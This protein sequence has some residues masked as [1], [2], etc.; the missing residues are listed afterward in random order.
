MDYL[1]KFLQKNC[2]KEKLTSEANLNSSFDIN[3]II[4]GDNITLINFAKL[5]LCIS[6]LCSIKDKHLTKV[7]FL[8]AET[9]NE[10]FSSVELFFSVDNNNEKQNNNFFDIN[11]FD[12]LNLSE[13]LMNDLKDLKMTEEEKKPEKKE[14]TTVLTLG[15]STFDVNNKISYEDNPFEKT[16]MESKYFG[17]ISETNNTNDNN[18][19]D[20]S[21]QLDINAIKQQLINNTK[22]LQPI[23]VEKKIYVNTAQ[24]TTE[25][26][27]NPVENKEKKNNFSN[28]DKYIQNPYTKSDKQTVIVEKKTYCDFVKIG[29]EGK[30]DITTNNNTKNTTTNTNKLTTLNSILN[31]NNDHLKPN[32]VNNIIITDKN[33]SP[34]NEISLFLSGGDF[35][36]KKIDILEETLMKNSEMYN[37]VIDKYEKE[38]KT[39]KEEI[40]NMKI[41]HKDELDNLSKEKKDYENKINNLSNLK[42]DNLTELDKIKNELNNEKIKYNELLIIKN[43]IEKEK[44]DNSNLNNIQINQKDKEILE[45]KKNLDELSKQLN[46]KDIENLQLKRTI[47]ELKEQKEKEL[48]DFQKQIKDVTYLKDQEISMLNDKIKSEQNNQ[49]LDR[50]QLEQNFENYKINSNKI[51][52]DL[53]NQ[54]N[55]LKR[56]VDEIPFLKQEIEKYKTLYDNIDNESAKLHKDVMDYQDRL[57]VGGKINQELNQEIEVL[58]RK[59][60]SDPY[61]A[62]EIM[63]KTL[64]NFAVRIMAEGN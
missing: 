26:E 21:G 28:I 61:F 13:S 30:P 6:S 63:S 16:D 64:Y 48:S 7:S 43:N 49:Q 33:M 18:N 5:L 51:N 12:N 25:P 2:Q 17:K 1:D 15:S 58:E 42:T 47:D 19:K 11:N 37:Y 9:Q 38:L 41:K 46:K 27:I 34:V 31:P 23:E 39:L 52:N 4:N 62:K 8:E 57:E 40:E 56:Q 20:T 35:L 53:M 45:L 50:T 24:E 36:H 29:Q 22:N 10:Y 44:N 60:N 3:K 32:I 55:L 59:L 14:E 54:N